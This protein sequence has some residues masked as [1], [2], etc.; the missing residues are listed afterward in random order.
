M[1][2]R[3][4]LKLRR[5]ALASQQGDLCCDSNHD[6]DDRYDKCQSSGACHGLP[7]HPDAYPTG[8]SLSA[9]SMEQWL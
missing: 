4:I 6:Q 7:I 5:E 3:W 9:D 2:D 1:F 8:Q